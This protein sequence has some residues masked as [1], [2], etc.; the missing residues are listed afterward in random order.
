MLLYGSGGLLALILVLV[1]GWS[2][3]RFDGGANPVL[4]Y[5]GMTTL[6]LIV[7]VASGSVLAAVPMVMCGVLTGYLFWKRDVL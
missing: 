7:L 6:S 5:A 4:E 3:V 1:G 2:S